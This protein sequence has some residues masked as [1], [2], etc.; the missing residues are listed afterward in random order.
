MATLSSGYFTAMS[1]M[2]INNG[3]NAT[4]TAVTFIAI[5]LIIIFPVVVYH[6]K[7]RAVKNRILLVENETVYTD[8]DLFWQGGIYNNPNDFNTLVEKRVRFGT[9]VNIAS[10]GGKILIASIVPL[11]VLWVGIAVYML[12]FDFGTVTIELSAQTATINAPMNR[13]T[14]SA[15]EVISVSM[16]EDM[17]HAGRVNHVSHGRIISGVSHVRGYGES[18][19]FVL[20][21][22]APYIRIELERGYVFLNGST[23]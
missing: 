13:F 16:L 2:A 14:F 12:P 9:T 4:L 8:N 1:F 3:L 11:I 10:K 18:H 5:C 23:Q 15:N 6:N 17:P 21:G 20:R 22:N 7:I 19:V